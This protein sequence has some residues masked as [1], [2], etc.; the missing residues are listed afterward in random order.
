MV[1]KIVFAVVSILALASPGDEPLKDAF[2]QRFRL[3]VAIPSGVYAGEGNAMR[4][5]VTTHFN[6]ITAENEMKPCSLQPS[7]GV[8]RWETADKLVAFGE[9][10]GMKIIGH[11]LVWHQQTP[12][13]F[14]IGED[15]RET[16][17]ETLIARM[18]AH[19]HAVVGRY[20]GR[21]HGW[22]VANEV[23]D[24]NGALRN[25][26]WARIIG[27]DFVE[28]AFRFAH[29]ADPDAELYYNDY[30][31]AS[32]GKRSAV[33]NM[34]RDFRNKGVRIDG[35]GMQTHANLEQPNIADY[36]ASLAAFADEGVKVM[37]TEMD[38]SVLPN[39]WDL[40]AEITVRHEYSEDLDPWKD[41]VLP[42]EIDR[43]LTQRWAEFFQVFLR[44]ADAIDRVTVWGVADGESWL[45]DFPV[46]GR[47]DYPL[48][49]D[50]SFEMKNCAKAIRELARREVA[51]AKNAPSRR[52]ALFRNFEMTDETPQPSFD[53][54]VSYANPIL[55]GMAPDPSITRKG[56]DYYL[57]NSSFSYFPGIPVWHSTNLVD[58][59][60]CGYCAARPSQLALRDGIDLSAGVFAPDIKYNPYNDTFYLIVTIVG[61]EGNVIYKTKDPRIGWSEPIKVPVGGIDPSM[62]F[63]DD[64]TAWILNNDDA[65]DDKPEYPGHRT[66]RMRRYDLV[67]DKVVPGTERIII[68]KG[69]HPEEKP[70]WC[71]GPHLY[72]ID[73]T[74]YVMTAEGGTGGWHSEVIWRSQS[75]EG[76]YSPCPVN[77]ILTQRDI[78]DAEVTCAGHA[79]LVQTPDG[80]W[81]AVFLGVVPYRV[82]GRDFCPTGRST[83]L[84]PVKWIGEGD[85]R[86]PI[87]LDKGKRIPMIVNRKEPSATNQAPG[88]S[89]QEPLWFQIRTP[90]ETWYRGT[91]D[92]ESG[93][94]LTPRAV[95]IYEKK[96]P[97]AL[98]RWIK[99]SR[100]T[101]SVDVEFDAKN[102]G[103]LAGFVLYQNEQCNYVLGVSADTAGRHI[104]VLY[105][106]DKSGVTRIATADAPS[107]SLRLKATAHDATVRFFW[108]TAASND[109][110][111]IGGE[112]DATILTTDYAGGFVGSA[113]GLYTEL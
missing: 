84:L 42:D 66:V 88:A 95:S 63:V 20:R 86:Q 87:I 21:V 104:V 27:S 24:E 45:N 15:G 47:T 61:G 34:V 81:W 44:H 11:C 50:R 96:N 31:M 38:V 78:K 108:R 8:F 79:D 97:S 12:R 49:F 85:T 106:A 100:F 73:G 56:G 75:I 80:D 71:E 29:E 111:Q 107:T 68:N 90:T 9:A 35:I 30:G 25:S 94:E 92:G 54:A 5:I 82:N 18:R 72:E 53:P 33:V 6:S 101:V 113:V 13:W 58:W 43:R 62:F 2:A 3:G 16:D 36:E 4:R 57:A 14:F 59:D 48:L 110:R 99:S 91:L 23:F 52:T 83:F 28:L 76:P 74:F 102:A 40:S 60:F 55:P 105:K 19:I 32:E 39:A 98:M 69:V 65:P 10:N 109:W 77:P 7:E 70:I 112:E 22:D 37:I 17:R 89:S 103:E 1:G 67:T 41:G 46:R 64:K 26:P 93:L 51:T